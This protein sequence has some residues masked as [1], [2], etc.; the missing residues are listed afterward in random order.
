MI[1]IYILTFDR[2]EDPNNSDFHYTNAQTKQKRLKKE[3]ALAVP[4]PIL[5]L[6]RS[7]SKHK[8]RS[9]TQYKKVQKDRNFAV[10]FL[11]TDV[12]NHMDEQPTVKMVP[13]EAERMRRCWKQTKAKREK[14]DCLVWKLQVDGATCGENDA[15]SYLSE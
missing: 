6:T 10:E 5:R 3:A 4:L 7:K 9:H 14:G 2:R 8:G 11:I 1:N 12:G 15:I 13:V